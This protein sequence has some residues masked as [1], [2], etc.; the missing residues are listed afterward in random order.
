[1]MRRLALSVLLPAMILSAPF[2]A[3]K[4]VEVKMLNRNAS[5]PMVYEPDYLVMEP[6]DT[7]RF[8]P[9]APGHN[10][11]SIDE[12][13]PAGAE[14]FKGQI[15]EE[16]EVTLTEPGIYGIKC[17]PHF[18]MGMVMLIQVGTQPAAEADLPAGLPTRADKRL[19]EI[20]ARQDTGSEQAEAHP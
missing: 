14:P 4:T 17:S 2:A 18:A 9:T 19:R 10:A 12:M 3:A 5:G 15:N 11:G 8:L 20:I 6:G 13:L 1:M 16:I 7:V